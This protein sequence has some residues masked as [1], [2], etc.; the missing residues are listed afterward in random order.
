M[1]M[2]IMLLLLLLMMM[3]IINEGDYHDHIIFP[4]AAVECRCL[5]LTK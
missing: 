4:M 3:M 1:M 2:M 5:T